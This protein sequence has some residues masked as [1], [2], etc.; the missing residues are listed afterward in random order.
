MRKFQEM[1][2]NFKKFCTVK[3]LGIIVTP[4]CIHY[5]YKHGFNNCVTK[6]KKNLFDPFHTIRNYFKNP[7]I[8]PCRTTLMIFF[9]FFKAIQ[10]LLSIVG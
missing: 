10:Y 1:E 8:N 5:G 6:K 3:I 9:F 4:F 7:F 2:R